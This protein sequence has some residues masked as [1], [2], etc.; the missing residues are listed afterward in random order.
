MG[1]SILVG[2][3]GAK[4][5]SSLA[6]KQADAVTKKELSIALQKLLEGKDSNEH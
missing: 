5:L 6:D 3:S 4:M 1:G 2:I